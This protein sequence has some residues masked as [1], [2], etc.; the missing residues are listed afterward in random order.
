MPVGTVSV[1][2]ADVK[3]S[4]YFGSIVE[5]EPAISPGDVNGDSEVGIADVTALINYLLTGDDSNVDIS[6]AD[7]NGDSEVG[8]ADVTVLINYLLTGNWWIESG[9]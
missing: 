9:D 4:Q 3:W 2:Q 1:Y 8:I 6:N 7:V 5:M